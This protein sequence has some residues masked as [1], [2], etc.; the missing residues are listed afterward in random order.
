[1][2]NLAEEDIRR[3]GIRSED[4]RQRIRAQSCNKTVISIESNQEEIPFQSAY[5]QLRFLVCRLD[6]PAQ[7]MDCSKWPGC[8]AKA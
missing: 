5:S 2:G 1:M 7:A 8:Y 6:G 4:S 3:P